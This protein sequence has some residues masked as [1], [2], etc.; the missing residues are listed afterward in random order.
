MYVRTMPAPSRGMGFLP[1]LVAAMPAITAAAGGAAQVITAAKGGGKSS[2][3]AQSNTPKDKSSSSGG[4]PWGL[5]KT[6]VVIGGVS[7]LALGIA[8]GGR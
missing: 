3:P 6:T 5:S 2:P 1:A 7:L 8:L 4:E